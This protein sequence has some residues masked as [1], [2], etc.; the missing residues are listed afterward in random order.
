[1]TTINLR[2]TSELKSSDQKPIYYIKGE[3]LNSHFAM[4]VQPVS[5][6]YIE[7]QENFKLPQLGEHLETD[8][9]SAPIYFLN[10]ENKDP[11]EFYGSDHNSGRLWYGKSEDMNDI[12]VKVEDAYKQYCS[13]N[14]YSQL[15]DQNVPM[16][17]SPFFRWNFEDGTSLIISYVDS[18]YQNFPE[19]NAIFGNNIIS[20]P[21][22]AVIDDRLAHEFVQPYV[23]KLLSK[24]KLEQDIDPDDLGDID[25]YP[26]EVNGKTLSSKHHKLLLDLSYHLYCSL[27]QWHE[28]ENNDDIDASNLLF[29]KKLSKYH[30]IKNLEIPQD[31][32]TQRL[33]FQQ[34]NSHKEYSISL[35]NNN[36]LWSVDVDY[37]PVGKKMTHENK[38]S[39]S[40]LKEAQDIYVETL[41]DKLQR[42][43]EMENIQLGKKLKI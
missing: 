13:K 30:L 22:G 27:M 23:A 4:G 14:P 12:H 2:N 42:G 31:E 16:S 39:T 29:A 37:G 38:I 36:N 41:R 35:K 20:Y 9:F 34:D 24:I 43:Y 3:F 8:N 21:F 18:D 26:M 40:S 15:T 28:G 33:V 17:Q 11:W 1:M 5:I 25:D 32:T 6:T 19:L 7:T 10:L